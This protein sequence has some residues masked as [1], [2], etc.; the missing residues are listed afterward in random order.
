M[1]R[2][3]WYNSIYQSGKSDYDF[4][5]LKQL[6]FLGG[7]MHILPP[8]SLF[9]GGSCPR[10]SPLLASMLSAGHRQATVVS[11]IWWCQPMETHVD[12]HRQLQ[13]NV[14]ADG[15]PVKFVKYQGDMI[16]LPCSCHRVLND[17]SL[18]QQ[19]VDDTVQQAVA[20]V[21]TAADERVHECLH[22]PY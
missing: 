6:K 7:N 12:D 13:P 17:L 2:Y 18:L 8:Q 5:P 15:Q 11:Q 9:L 20:V 3:V 21:E 19:L 1:C 14:L 10:C 16:E 22:V 4:K